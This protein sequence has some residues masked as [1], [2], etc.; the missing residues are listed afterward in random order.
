MHHQ[1]LEVD[2]WL[3]ETNARDPGLGGGDKSPRSLVG[4]RN[5][6]RELLASDVT[7]IC[8]IA[9]GYISRHVGSFPGTSGFR[10]VY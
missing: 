10:R 3:S 6:L 1:N 8:G 5:V 7:M 2:A 4:L 9:A